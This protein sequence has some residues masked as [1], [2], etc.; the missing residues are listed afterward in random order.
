[1]MQY[2]ISQSYLLGSKTP[3][4]LKT[5]ATI[6]TVELT[7]LEMTRTKA[8][9]AVVAIAVARSRTMP[10]LIYVSISDERMYVVQ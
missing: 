3:F 5:S 7:G 4:F 2:H 9:G 6:G 8:F 10:A 1:M